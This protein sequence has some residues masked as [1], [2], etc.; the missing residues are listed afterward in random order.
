[1]ERSGCIAAH[2]SLLHL[3]IAAP[4]RALGSSNP[5]RPDPAAKS[6]LQPGNYR[7][8]SNQRGQALP[9]ALECPCWRPQAGRTARWRSRTTARCARGS[10]H[11]R[12]PLQAAAPCRRTVTRGDCAPAKAALTPS[13]PAGRRSCCLASLAGSAGSWASCSSSRGPGS[14]TLPP[15]W[16]IGRAW[17]RTSSGCGQ[18]PPAFKSGQFQNRRTTRG[19]PP[20][21]CPGGAGEAHARAQRGRPDRAAQRGLVRGPQGAR[22]ARPAPGSPGQPPPAAAGLLRACISRAHGLPTPAARRC[23]CMHGWRPYVRRTRAVWLCGGALHIAAGVA[24]RRPSRARRPRRCAQIETIRA[25]VLGMLNLADVCFQRNIHLTTYATGCIFHYDKDFPEG[26]GKG[27]KEED[28][29]NFTGSYYSYTKARA[30][31]RARRA[32]L[33]SSARRCTLPAA[34]RPACASALRPRLTLGLCPPRAFTA[35]GAP[36]GDGG[37][38]SEG[39]PQC[40]GAARAD[41]HRGRPHV[42]AQLHHQ[43]NQIRE[44]APPRRSRGAPPRGPRHSRRA[45]AAGDMLSVRAR[46]QIVNIPNSMTVLPELLPLSLEMARPR[47]G[48]F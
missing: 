42:P 39:V 47:A 30:C 29:P 27:F 36:A 31:T 43:D 15:A 11:A 18:P 35:P 28:T 32:V 16:R 3:S 37:E 5:A 22:R 4:S 46:A 14:N 41:A 9:I 23:M 13:V 24:A 10:T 1:M 20:R 45:R 19:Q 8:I 2:W 38:P 6:A 25:N 21:L 40:A 12:A 7:E 33:S 34:R 48:L 17:W 26:S 44:G